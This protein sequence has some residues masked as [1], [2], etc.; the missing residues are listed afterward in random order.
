[1]AADLD[2][3]EHTAL[4]PQDDEET[5]NNKENDPPPGGAGR[6][7]LLSLW[8]RRGRRHVPATGNSPHI[9]ST[10]VVIAEDEED[11][12]EAVAAVQE[13]T[14]VAVAPMQKLPLMRVEEEDESD[15]A[16][17]ALESELEALTD[18]V[19]RLGTDI[20]VG[21]SS[22]PS[23]IGRNSGSGSGGALGALEASLGE[24]L[25]HANASPPTLLSPGARPPRAPSRSSIGSGWCGSPSPDM[26]GLSSCMATRTPCNTPE[27]L[28][29]ALDLCASPA[30]EE[31][32]Q[33]QLR[34][35]LEE[36]WRSPRRGHGFHK[37]HGGLRKHILQ[38]RAASMMRDADQ[39]RH[40]DGNPLPLS[41]D[42][43]RITWA[44]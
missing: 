27:P 39:V 33:L 32:I 41:P 15:L 13:E 4:L 36:K 2:P 9:V 1:M 16:A 30:D 29:P 20:A 28:R 11:D 22:P 34:E 31:A 10:P 35:E 12:A 21:A 7:G 5:S 26:F 24:R 8:R 18:A 23:S 17:E 14:R 42:A 38:L 3:T 40:R 44:C 25:R 6:P 37:A 43:T 19:R